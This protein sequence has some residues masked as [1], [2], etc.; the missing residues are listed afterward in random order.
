MFASGVIITGGKRRS[1]TNLATDATDPSPRH[2]QLWPHVRAS[3]A[4]SDGTLTWGQGLVHSQ[5]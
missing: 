5:V 1:D 3:A 4:F 2:V